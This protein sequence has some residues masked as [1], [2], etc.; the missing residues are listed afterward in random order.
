MG[1]RDKTKTKKLICK[2]TAQVVPVSPFKHADIVTTTTHK[3]LR[4]PR[5]AM[6]FFRKGV[7]ASLSQTLYL[8]CQATR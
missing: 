2:S 7:K 1:W 4:G 6:V 8:L 3:S 5:G